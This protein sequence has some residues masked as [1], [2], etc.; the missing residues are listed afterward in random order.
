MDDYA[1][2]RPKSILIVDDHSIIRRTLGEWLG[3]E[4]PGVHIT[5]ASNAEEALQ[6]LQ[7]DDPPDLILMDFHLPGRSG[8]AASKVI[9]QKHPALPI[10][11]LTIQE[12][13]QYLKRARAAGVDGYVVKRKMY[14]DLV[15]AISGVLPK[16]GQ[17]KDVI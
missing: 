10:V 8:I 13:E 17:T 5:E 6:S 2:P 15:P 11:M 3:E 14:T 7:A 12:G 1:G 16:N 4:F 9:K